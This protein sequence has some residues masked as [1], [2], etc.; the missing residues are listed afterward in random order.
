[1]FKKMF[2]SV[3]LGCLIAFVLVP[4]VNVGAAENTSADIPVTLEYGT[5]RSISYGKLVNDTTF[6]HVRSFS[7]ENGAVEVS[8]DAKTNSAYVTC[9]NLTVTAKVGAPYI[10]A[11]GRV[12]Y[13]GR[14]NFVEDGKLY[15]PARSL[16]RAF[17]F[18]IIWNAENGSVHVVNEGTPIEDAEF[19]YNKNDLYWLSRIIS[20]EAGGTEPLIG[21]IA[22]GNVVLNRVGDES[23]PD[24]VFDVIFDKRYGIQF[25]PAYT[26][27]IYKEPFEISVIAAKICLEGYSV[28]EDALFFYAPKYTYAAWIEETRDYLFTIGG[29]KFFA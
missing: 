13:S 2:K 20:C 23:S 22:V 3:A 6:F 28:T 1:M 21:Q 5:S 10:V 7:D 11:N 26:P 15:V 12:V 19:F 24:T 25:A 17:G 16:C 14:E 4:M 9:P 27:N 18:D 29:H 8:W